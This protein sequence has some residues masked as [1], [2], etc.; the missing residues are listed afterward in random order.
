[1]LL[2]TYMSKTN[3]LFM[4]KQAEQLEWLA[5]LFEHHLQRLSQQPRLEEQRKLLRGIEI[6][7]ENI[8]RMILS[9]L[10]TD[11][12]NSPAPESSLQLQSHK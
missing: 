1:M 8:D 5:A 12:L 11:T 6:L 7:R 3:I 4:A 10:E 9:G 2:S